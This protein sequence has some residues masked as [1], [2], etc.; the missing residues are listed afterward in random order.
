MIL[1]SLTFSRISPKQLCFDIFHINMEVCDLGKMQTKNLDLS[2]KIHYWVSIIYKLR[3]IWCKASTAGSPSIYDH[4]CPITYGSRLIA[5]F[6]RMVLWE[7]CGFS[8]YDCQMVMGAL[9]QDEVWHVYPNSCMTQ[10]CKCLG[11]LSG[12]HIYHHYYP[13][14]LDKYWVKQV[15]QLRRNLSWAHRSFLITYSLVSH[16]EFGGKAV[17]LILEN[18]FNLKLINFTNIY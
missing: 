13:P 1:F 3:C 11:S 9:L 16:N 4:L 15:L 18:N 10:Q 14:H 8:F 7:R 5:K 17:R 6:N 12:W 2:V